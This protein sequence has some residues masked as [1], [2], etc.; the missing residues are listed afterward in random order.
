MRVAALDL[1][2]NTFLC[3]IADVDALGNVNVIK[4]SV[5]VVRLAQGVGESGKLCAEALERAKFCLERFAEDIRQ[6]QPE[7][8]LGV[9]T[10]AARRADNG[11]R[12]LDLGNALSIPIQIISGEQEAELTFLGASTE[13][14]DSKDYVV[15]DIGGGST[16]IIW[17]SPQGIAFKKSFEIGVVKLRELFVKGFPVDPTTVNQIDKTIAENFAELRGVSSQRKGPVVAVAGTPTTLAAAAL[18]GFDARKIDGYRFSIEDLAQWREILVA[19]TPEQIEVNFSVPRGRSDVL[20]VGVM[21]LH[22]ALEALG[23]SELTVSVRGLRYG[24]AKTVAKG[25][26]INGN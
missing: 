17:G 26:G 10:A 15:I 22:G 12:L 9:A 4:D 19:M 20:A 21:I 5:E 18:G 25:S 24:L 13:H 3:L 1:G 16:E 23:F 2:S 6:H 11:Q 8:I 14:S 7:K